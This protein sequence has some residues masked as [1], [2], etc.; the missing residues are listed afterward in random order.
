M[1][2]LIRLLLGLGFAISIASAGTE[3]APIPFS[4]GKQEFKAGD[5]IVI[6]Q[7]LATSPQLESGSKVTVRGHYQLA[8]TPQAK[9]GLF[10]THRAPAGSDP[11]APAQIQPIDHASG[12][13]ELS[14]EITYAGDLHV[15]FYP[16]AR[17]AAFGGVYIGAT[18]KP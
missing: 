10:V 16:V 2:T 17:G 7:V 4:V 6:D 11:V 13:F 12:T 3:L 18:P 1:K 9:L 15:S 14:C 5:T 8:S